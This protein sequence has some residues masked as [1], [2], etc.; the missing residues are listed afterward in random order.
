MKYKINLIKVGRG[1][2]TKEIITTDCFGIT[3]AE[4]FAVNEVGKHLMSKGVEIQEESTGV[5]GV[6]V[7]LGRRVGEVRI[8]KI[9]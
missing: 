1:K 3:E 4:L 5:Y 8:K 6:N 7:G 2:V 9:R